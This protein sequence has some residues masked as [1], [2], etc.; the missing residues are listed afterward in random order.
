MKA[1]ITFPH[2]FNETNPGDEVYIMEIPNSRCFD[3]PEPGL[4]YE[5]EIQKAYIRNNIKVLYN[6]IHPDKGVSNVEFDFEGEPP[7]EPFYIVKDSYDGER[8]FSG[9]Q[10][11]CE[12]WVLDNWDNRRDFKI[13][14]KLG[15]YVEEEVFEL[16]DHLKQQKS[17]WVIDHNQIETHRLLGSSK[18][19]RGVLIKYHLLLNAR[20]SK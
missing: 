19:L 6:S 3:E 13:I 12:R 1:I 4:K 18:V 5:A 20:Y 2:Y 15:N 14:P 10:G 8:L 11:A 9:T 16:P 7:K 17:N